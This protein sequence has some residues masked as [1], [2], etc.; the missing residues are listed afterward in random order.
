[1]K[2][3]HTAPMFQPWLT[4]FAIR[5]LGVSLGLWLGMMTAY[6]FDLK[7]Y[8][9]SGTEYDE[10]IPKPE[11]Y[12]GFR[13][14]Q[15]H[16]HHHELIGYL[17]E[18]SAHSKRV[19]W[20]EY[21]RTHGGKPLL[22]FVITSPDNHAKL[23]MLREEH[24]KLLDHKI[25]GELNL[26]DMPAVINMGYS[27]HGDEPSGANAVP[28][29]AYHLV[30]GRGKQ[31]RQLLKN[32][33]ILL[34][35]CLNPDG[36][37]RFANWANNHRGQVPNRDRNHRE[38]QQA[39]P[40]GRTNYY[41]FDLNRDW[42]PAQ[43]PE[44]QGRL[45]QFHRWMPNV[46]LDFHEMGTDSTFFFQPGIEARNHPLIPTRNL[47]LTD[48]ISRYH[49]RALD[50]IG[51]L[52]YTRE[53]FDDFYLGKGSSYP[54]LHGGI[55][56]LFEQASSR[57]HIQESIR[58]DITFPFTIRNH[59]RTS[60][61]SLQAT[62]EKRSELHDHLRTF[63]RDAAEAAKQAT[64]KTYIFTAAHDP[65][66]LYEFAQILKRHQIQG[67]Q[68]R[69]DM[70]VGN[71]T[72]TANDSIVVP[73]EQREY[74]FVRAL[75]DRPTNFKENIF[76]DTS[77]WTL[78][79]AFNLRSAELPDPANPEWLGKPIAEMEFPKM[80]F[81]PDEQD[82][83]YTI[84]YR[85]YY[86]PRTLYRL[87]SAQV[88]V[89]VSESPLTTAEGTTVPAGTLMVHV[90]SQP[91]KREII[92]RILAEAAE[93]D[94][95][96]VLVTRTGLTPAGSDLGSS[97]LR[98]LNIPRILLAIGA[99]VVTSEAGEAWHLLDRRFGIPVT[100]VEADRLGT[101][102]LSQYSH[103]VLPSGSY[104]SISDTEVARI[105]SWLNRGGTIVGLGSSVRWLESKKLANIRLRSTRSATPQGMS[106]QR[107][108]FAS[109]ETNADLQLVSGAIFQVELDVTHPLAY[110]YT[111]D[112]LFVFRDQRIFMEPSSNPYSTPAIY[113]TNDQQAGQISGYLS[114][115]NRQT[116]AE[117]ASIIVDGVGAGRVIAM[118]DNPNFRA[119]WHGTN[120]IFLN[121][122]FLSP[123]VIEPSSE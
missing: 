114:K 9:P 23:E 51:S 41:W 57:G 24:L 69:K 8:L 43:H 7:E 45:V 27:I 99:G 74:M 120:R 108:P 106:R 80:K 34:D 100:L 83:A 25:S 66:R 60:L 50:E 10:K 84:D 122:L 116:L 109:A 92:Q 59:V 61:S 111:D 115:E 96:P 118:V 95:T 107:Q 91:E 103:V 6:S 75:C 104:S 65:V 64:T 102:D 17:K 88:R 68:L 52:Y 58:G 26:A 1:M 94:G 49:A 28:V 110:G 79:A 78:P 112:R 32:T 113:P 54:D 44:S 40:S 82:L 33:I 48:E 76:Y 97:T 87:L 117:S 11:D 89:Q 73:A 14:G 81:A 123:L 62:F 71:V 47:Q 90:G 55:G 31:L 15:R 36:F 121:A 93:Q 4:T 53:G 13:I 63:Y 12:L 29:V 85:S 2:Y 86:T 22:M 35:P 70:T 98:Q 42:L 5:A 67:F 119:Y 3:Q 19:T 18:L 30:A 56:I 21:A 38:H 105:Q 39:W 72:H 20:F 101:V 46:L 16:I 77:A 37:D